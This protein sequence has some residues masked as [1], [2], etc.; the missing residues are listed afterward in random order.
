MRPRQ[1]ARIESGS[2]STPKHAWTWAAVGCML[3]LAI[4]AAQLQTRVAHAEQ[5]SR[6]DVEAAYL[7][8]FGKFV[9]WPASEGHGPMV[10]CVAGQDNLGQTA[11]RL[12]EGEQ[13]DGHSLVV[14][15]AN[16]P[17]HVA[18]CSILYVDS[19]EGSRQEAFLK[20]SSGKP[21]LTVGDS[22]DF[23]ER[24]GILQFVVTGDH[25][26]FSA[27]LDAASRNGLSLSSELLKV[28][29]SVRRSPEKGGAR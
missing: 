14:Q 1:D 4:G 29:V 27:N 23:L 11:K 18:P 21:I 17:D 10:I 25:I 20:A 6:D 28:A 2:I 12:I 22:P 15:T 8:N 26:R 5:P 13:I 16:A 9:R 19:S 7:F 3:A 24:G